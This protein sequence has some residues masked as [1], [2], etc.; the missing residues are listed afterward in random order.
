VV[1]DCGPTAALDIHDD[2]GG[3]VELV[4]EG[5]P[6]FT[7]PSPQHAVLMPRSEFR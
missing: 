2:I 6:S 1:S 7:G 3:P 4:D 5:R